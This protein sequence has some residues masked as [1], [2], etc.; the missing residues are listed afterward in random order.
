MKIPVDETQATGEERAEQKKKEIEAEFLRYK[1]ARRAA[2]QRHAEEKANRD[3]EG[4]DPGIEI[5]EVEVGQIKDRFEK[6][7]IFTS[8]HGDKSELDVEIKMAGKAREKFK[9]IDAEGSHPVAPSHEN[10]ERVASKWDKKDNII[11]P[12]PVNK[13]VIED[14]VDEPEDEDAYDVKNLMNKFKNIEKEPVKLTTHERPTDLEGIKVEARSL[15]EQF[16]KVG[17]SENENIDEKRKIIEEEFA[18]LKQ[19]KEAAAAAARESTPE[20]ERTPTKEEIHIAA[21]HASKM[22][23]KWEKIQQKEAKKAKKSKMPA[24]SAVHAML[25]A[26]I[27]SIPRCSSC[28]GD[29]Y[30]TELFQYLSNVYHRQCFRC[31]HCSSILRVDNCQRSPEGSLFCETHYRR[32]FMLPNFVLRDK[33]SCSRSIVNAMKLDSKS[34][35]LEK[36]ELEVMVVIVSTSFTVSRGE[37]NISDEL[38]LIERISSIDV[39]LTLPDLPMSDGTTISGYTIG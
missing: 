20:E 21:D 35:D 7:N 32:F 3:S 1:L 16:E 29:V 31:T 39:A 30:I 27:S 24:K 12:E 4:N 14:D 10:K 25:N 18:R 11:V 22:T 36:F 19:E 8:Q 15:K 6:G 34:N 2:A 13:R 33:Q 38:A 5:P 26:R 9:Q 17:E 23:A 37:I 28:G